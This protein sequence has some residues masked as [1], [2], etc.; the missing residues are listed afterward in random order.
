MNVLVR[1]VPLTACFLLLSLSA[2]AQDNRSYERYQEVDIVDPEGR[3]AVAGNEEWEYAKTGIYDLNG[4]GNKELVVLT[5]NADVD[6]SGE[7]QWSDGHRWQ[8]YIQDL[9]GERTYVFANFVQL[10]S[11]K[12]SVTERRN[13]KRSILLRIHRENVTFRVYEILYEGT[14]KFRTLKWGARTPRGELRNPSEFVRNRAPHRS[15]KE[16]RETMDLLRKRQKEMSKA[17]ADTTRRSG[18]RIDGGD[19]PF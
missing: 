17:P 6:S 2:L 19:E 9:S 13:G 4:N 8:L 3:R 11:P 12:I 15:A 18:G 10:T 16:L 1:A 7:P 14:G 5:A